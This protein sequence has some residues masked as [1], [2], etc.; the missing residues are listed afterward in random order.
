MKI[1]KYFDTLS[2]CNQNGYTKKKKNPLKTVNAVKNRNGWGETPRYMLTG[3]FVFVCFLIPFYFLN[4][5]FVCVCLYLSVCGCAASVCRCICVYIRVKV[6]IEEYLPLLLFILLF[7][8]SF[9]TWSHY[10]ILTGLTL[11]M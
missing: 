10:V 7:V 1:K 5:Y 8:S 2:Y 9:N 4:I 11:C 3:C 6:Y